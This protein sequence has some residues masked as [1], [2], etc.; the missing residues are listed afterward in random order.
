MKKKKKNTKDKPLIFFN[1]MELRNGL[2][3]CLVQNIQW[4]DSMTIE[5][6]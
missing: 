6:S 5:R 4:T 2:R 1:G 3:A